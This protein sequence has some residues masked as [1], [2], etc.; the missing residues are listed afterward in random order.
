MSVSEHLTL[1][2]APAELLMISASIV[3]VFLIVII[4]QIIIIL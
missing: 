2:S 4:I 3:S 1:Q